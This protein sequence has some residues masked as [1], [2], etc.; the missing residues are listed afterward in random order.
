MTIL[1]DICDWEDRKFREF[2]PAV[3]G[4]VLN[5][6]LCEGFH[7]LTSGFHYENPFKTNGKC[8]PGEIITKE[9]LPQD[10]PVSVSMVLCGTSSRK[11]CP[12]RV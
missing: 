11:L 7:N 9:P 5:G 4:C 3:L 12:V 2:T 6:C 1:G 8:Q 10:P